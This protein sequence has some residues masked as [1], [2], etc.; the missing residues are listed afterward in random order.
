[1]YKETII[2]EIRTNLLFYS[3]KQQFHARSLRI[4]QIVPPKKEQYEID[5]YR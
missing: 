1:M 2:H 3:N 4:M 5:T